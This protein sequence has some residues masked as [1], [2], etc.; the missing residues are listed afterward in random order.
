MDQDLLAAV[1]ARMPET[2]FV[3]VGPLQTEVARLA[4][5]PNVHFLGARPHAAVPGYIG[6][7]DVGLVPYR[8]TPYTAHVCPSK[9][10]E[11]LA[12]GIPVVATD[13][14][15]IRRFN[16]EHG[17]VVAVGRDPDTFT[18]AIRSAVGERSPVEIARRIEV[19][20]R[21]GWDERIGAMLTLLE[22]GLNARPRDA[23][24]RAANGRARA[25][26]AR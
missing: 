14:P 11:Y 12:M 15:A 22:E 3:L 10:N 5:A 13:L 4:R 7:F 24:P 19:A 21:N 23:R 1:A 26:R 25:G 8:L 20:R 6:G 17:P 9:L 18:A 2:S 16:D